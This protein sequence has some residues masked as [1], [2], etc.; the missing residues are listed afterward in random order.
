MWSWSS[1]DSDCVLHHRGYVV[2]LK[3]DGEL[4]SSEVDSLSTRLMAVP[5]LTTVSALIV[6]FSPRLWTNA[7]VIKM[8]QC[9]CLPRK[10]WWAHACLCPLTAIP[11]RRN[12]FKT[13]GSLTATHWEELSAIHVN[14]KFLQYAPRKEVHFLNMERYCLYV[15][16]KD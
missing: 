1:V 6:L 15:D 9:A 7:S 4:V 13:M 16:T 10:L 12:S 3:F 2:C 8:P 14:T 11:Q 5:S